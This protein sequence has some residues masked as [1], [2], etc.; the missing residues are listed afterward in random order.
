MHQDGCGTRGCGTKLRGGGQ[1]RHAT[2]VYRGS[3]PGGWLAAAAPAPRKAAGA[4]A[5][6]VEALPPRVSGKGG[7]WPVPPC[8]QAGPGVCPTPACKT[9]PSRG[10]ASSGSGC[11]DGNNG[12]AYER[13]RS[14]STGVTGAVGVARFSSKLIVSCSVQASLCGTKRNPKSRIRRRSPDAWFAWVLAVQPRLLHY[15]QPA[16]WRST[17][18]RV[19]QVDGN[20]VIPQR[21][22]EGSI[23]FNIFP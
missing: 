7:R 4:R 5:S 1:Q 9:A 16:R 20:P 10:S 19:S 14:G 18:I 22:Q 2:P 8:C 17:S 11:A 15:S 13:P 21:L 6:E 12:A 23:E 3:G